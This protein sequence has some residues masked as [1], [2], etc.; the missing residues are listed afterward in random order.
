[1]KPFNVDPIIKEG[2]SISARHEGNAVYLKMVGNGDME[3]PAT[4]GGYLKKIHGEALRLRAHSVMVECEELY[5]MSSA[6]IKCMV[7]WIDG[8]V[9][10]EPAERYKVKLHA[11]PNLPWQ[12]RSFEALR[13][14][15]PALV[16]IDSDSANTQAAPVSGTMAQSTGTGSTP[17]TPAAAAT[18]SGPSSSTMTSTSSA[19]LPAALP[20]AARRKP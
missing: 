2:F 16:H 8:I 11:N 6:C 12:R 3:T 14:F 13:R 9:K 18:G 17:R 20:S 10:L 4:L 19:G 1:M 5:F 15:A 7:T